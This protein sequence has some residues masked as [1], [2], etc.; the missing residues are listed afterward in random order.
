MA[1]SLEGVTFITGSGDWGVGCEVES[2]CTR[3]T[4]DFPS[5]SPYV[6]STGATTYSE[7]NKEEI[8]VSFSSGGFSNY[9]PRP[10]FQDT[11]VNA[12]LK[13]KDLPP[14][15]FFN[16]SGRAFPDISTIGTGFVVFTGGKR[17][18]VGGTS[19]AT[20]TFGSMLSMINSVRIAS[21]KPVL[22]YALP[23]LYSA[24]NASPNAFH[25]K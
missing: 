22:G 24:W 25:G 21:G 3:F 8:G 18:P 2:E 16:N 7:G 9:F 20:P 19:A 6:I 1:Y 12:F 17:G 23:F 14:Q 5:S 4:S 13:Q 10:S 15:S 11:A